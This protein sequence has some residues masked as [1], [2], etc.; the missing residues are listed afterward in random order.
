M[1]RTAVWSIPCPRFLA[2]A[3]LRR[4]IRASMG[5]RMVGNLSAALVDSRDFRKAKL[6]WTWTYR[7]GTLF[8]DLELYFAGLGE[9]SAAVGVVARSVCDRSERE[10]RKRS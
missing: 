6:V 7:A 10:R 8:W 4:R 3:L 1:D 5:N 2:A 9:R